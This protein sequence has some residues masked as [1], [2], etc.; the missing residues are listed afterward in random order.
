MFSRAGYSN[1]DQRLI[2]QPD[3]EENAVEETLI[4][5]EGPTYHNL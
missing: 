3:D 5:Q 2:N 4:S 1:D